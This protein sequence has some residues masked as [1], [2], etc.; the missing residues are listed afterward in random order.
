M[1]GP[2]ECARARGKPRID[3]D[4]G[5]TGISGVR[6]GE[7]RDRGAD[8]LRTRAALERQWFEQILPV[9]LTAGS[10]LR[11]FLHQRDQT[12]R[13]DRTGAQCDHADAIA[14]ADAT[15][16]LRESGK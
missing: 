13:F 15:E 9:V 16:R 5:A 4:N 12:I 2:S 7:E 8:L 14:R 11:L 1:W 10:V 3:G 6:R